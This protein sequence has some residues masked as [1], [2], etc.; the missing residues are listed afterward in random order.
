MDM[1]TTKTT[2]RTSEHADCAPASGHIAD[3]R[4]PSKE[5]ST[6]SIKIARDWSLCEQKNV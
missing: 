1:I 4:D 6:G 3:G 5:Q 2:Q